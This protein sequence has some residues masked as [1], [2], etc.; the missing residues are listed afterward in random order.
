[1]T[2]QL[3]FPDGRDHD[4]ICDEAMQ[5]TNPFYAPG[6]LAP[7]VY[8][9]HFQPGPWH[10]QPT[11]GMDQAPFQTWDTHRIV[12]NNEP[13]MFDWQA[14]PVGPWD[15]QA[16]S[17]S[18]VSHNGHVEAF[19]ASS[20]DANFQG[21]PLKFEKIYEP[22]A[23]W[24]TTQW[25]PGP[26]SIVEVGGDGQDRM[27]ISLP[28]SMSPDRASKRRR[29]SSMSTMGTQS[30]APM[31]SSMQLSP[32]IYT[33]AFENSEQPNH[34]PTPPFSLPSHMSPIK[35]SQT[36]V[37]SGQSGSPDE[38]LPSLYSAPDEPDEVMQSVEMPSTST[39]PIFQMS[40]VLI[41]SVR[42]ISDRRESLSKLR[43][44]SNA[45]FKT[46]SANAKRG[47]YASD[48]WE[49]H[50]AAIKKMYIDEGKPLREVIKTMETDHNF[51]ATLVQ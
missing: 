15:M 21:P 5:T 1:M 42:V 4:G 31:R 27:E 16:Q 8:S 37:S 40:P 13:V 18:A 34:L 51:P 49:G 25:I 26:S 12:N 9:S 14:S 39:G 10:Q 2:P 19:Q 22:S 46:Q 17:F 23:M 6:P 20:I 28:V 33:E 44:G 29:A 32:E 11:A 50:K 36:Y 48:V 38:E 47:H 3:Y 30:S 24:E 45:V 41:P 7:S 35:E 43:R